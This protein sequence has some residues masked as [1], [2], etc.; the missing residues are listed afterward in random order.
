MNM[1]REDGHNV[2]ICSEH[3]EYKNTEEKIDFD[4]PRMPKTMRTSVGFNWGKSKGPS[5]QRVIW[6]DENGDKWFI[7]KGI[8]H[9]AELEGSGS[10]KT[11]HYVMVTPDL[12]KQLEEGELEIQY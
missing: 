5:G 2:Y 4:Y 6:E 12:L 3:G 7:Y 10:R 9:Y 8:W 11:V 1:R